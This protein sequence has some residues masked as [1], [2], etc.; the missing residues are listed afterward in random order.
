MKRQKKIKKLLAN[1]TFSYS[2]RALGATFVAEQNQNQ[3][4]N[5]NFFLKCLRA[6]WKAPAVAAKWMQAEPSHWWCGAEAASPTPIPAPLPSE[7]PGLRSPS[8]EPSTPYSTI[9]GPSTVQKAA[10]PKTHSFQYLSRHPALRENLWAASSWAVS[11]PT[12]LCNW[13]HS[14]QMQSELQWW[15][16]FCLIS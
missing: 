6:T 15:L 4:C 5:L 3:N 12:E 16:K 13:A 2:L 9:L 7:I 10:I 11:S 1:W 8:A 14:V